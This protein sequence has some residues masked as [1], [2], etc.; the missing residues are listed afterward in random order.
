MSKRI[1]DTEKLFESTFERLEDGYLVY[2]WR[3][4]KGYWVSP[5][6][7]A[8]LKVKFRRLLSWQSLTSIGLAPAIILLLGAY[9]AIEWEWWNA[10]FW[11]MALVL[12]FL[13]FFIW[14]GLA[15]QRLVFGRDP[16][17]PRRSRETTDQAIARQLPW[18]LI[19]GPIVLL[20]LNL[21]LHWDKAVRFANGSPIIALILVIVFVVSLYYIYGVARAKWNQEKD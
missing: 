16:I 7:Y 18:L 17:A 8:G 9:A 4:S 19:I 2:P 1:F 10:I 11:A 14:Q 3:W 15:P 5:D 6:E 21:W 20:T 13:V 12:S